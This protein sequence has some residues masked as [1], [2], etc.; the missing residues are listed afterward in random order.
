[1]RSIVIAVLVVG[2]G[3]FGEPKQAWEKKPA[4]KEGEEGEEKAKPAEPYVAPTPDPP[5]ELSHEDVCRKMWQLIAD[6]ATA[7]SKKGGK[8]K[9]PGDKERSEFLQDCFKTGKDEAKSNPEKYNCQK[10]CIVEAKELA[11]VET[12]G[13]GCSK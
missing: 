12:C 2:C 13:K 8:N 6:D 4:A 3:G 9:V 1:M 7:K 11:D 5:K 10:K